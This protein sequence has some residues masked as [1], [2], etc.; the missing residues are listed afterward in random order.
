MKLSLPVAMMMLVDELLDFWESR[1]E[2]LPNSL[3]RFVTS[4]LWSTSV[5]IWGT[6]AEGLGV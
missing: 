1:A 4:P 2:L 5:I 3:P 6:D